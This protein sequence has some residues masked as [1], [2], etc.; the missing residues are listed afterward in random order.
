VPLET[1]SGLLLLLEQQTDMH[2]SMQLE[3][4]KLTPP[5]A[6]QQMHSSRNC[7][8]SQSSQQFNWSIV[9]GASIADCVK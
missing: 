5:M 9:H 3:V 6:H 8:S 2:T 1:N 7:G 4:Q